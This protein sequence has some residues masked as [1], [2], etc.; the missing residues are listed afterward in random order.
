[1]QGGNMY[2]TWHKSRSVRLKGFDYGAS[3]IAYHVIIGARGKRDVFTD[4]RINRR[5]IAVL[6]DAC[7]LHQ[8]SLIAYC[9]MP[10]HLHI[11]IRSG[12]NSSR[13]PQFVRAFKSYARSKV[14]R[15]LWQRGYYEHVMRTGEDLKITAEYILNNPVRKGMVE[16][17]GEYEWSGLIVEEGI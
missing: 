9:L 3:N 17:W 16:E 4:G 10:D 11:L 14:K 5:V 7:R 1:M 6:I 8:Y 13:L 15:N 2:K 12:E